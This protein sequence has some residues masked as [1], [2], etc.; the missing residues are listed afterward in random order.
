MLTPKP[1]TSLGVGHEERCQVTGYYNTTTA[2]I[3]SQ[4]KKGGQYNAKG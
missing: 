4:T 1:A 2:T 3:I